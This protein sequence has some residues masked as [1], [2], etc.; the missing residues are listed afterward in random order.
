MHVA[1][2][3]SEAAPESSLPYSAKNIRFHPVTPAGGDR[4]V[5]K[6]AVLGRVPEY[7]F[8]MNQEMRSAD[9]VHVRC[10]AAISMVALI[11]LLFKSKPKY[12]WVKYAGNWKPDGREAFSYAIQSWFLKNNLHRGVV[13]VNGHWKDQSR[14]IFSFLNPCLTD[15]EIQDADGTNAVKELK[16]PYQLLFV[17]RL[18]TEKGVGRILESAAQLQKMNVEFQLHL[19]GDGPER[20]QFELQAER[21]QIT[22]QTR[23]WGWLPRGSLHEHYKRSHFILLPS[24]ASEGWPK[25]LSEAMAYGVVVLASTIS[26]IPQILRETGAGLAIDPKEPQK[27]AET[28]LELINDPSEWKDYRQAARR[29]A[30][31]FSYSHY[32]D[33]LKQM[34][35]ETWGISF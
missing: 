29:S 9:I 16:P 8:A 3:H 33:S 31:L 35:G 17:G 23:F 22:Q 1:P 12:R 24:T 30:C 11:M 27:Y 26:S 28:I 5:Q 34:M 14:H 19:V 20:E 13:T 4:L 21:L 25:V 6:M 32:L 7:I 2:L 15:D 10:P 18:E